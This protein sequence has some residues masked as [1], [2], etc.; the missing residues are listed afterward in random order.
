MAMGCPWTSFFVT[1]QFVVLRATAKSPSSLDPLLITVPTLINYFSPRESQSAL[2][3][4]G[5]TKLS[6]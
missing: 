1:G 3:G 6:H 4:P 5:L 2:I